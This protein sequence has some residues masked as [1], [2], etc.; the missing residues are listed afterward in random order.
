[1]EQQTAT[2]AEERREEIDDL[3][4]GFLFYIEYAETFEEVKPAEWGDILDLIIPPIER[5]PLT[6]FFE[7]LK[8]RLKSSDELTKAAVKDVLK[9]RVAVLRREA[10][11]LRQRASEIENYAKNIE[12]L[13]GGI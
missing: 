6:T 11:K 7:L 5:L 12:N 3:Y 9:R 4:D 8:E 2:L 10:E 1:V 13:V